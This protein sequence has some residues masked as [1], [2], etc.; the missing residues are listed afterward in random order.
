MTF[1]KEE[2]EETSRNVYKMANLTV[3]FSIISEKN[4]DK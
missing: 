3:I 2:T 1:E 4:R